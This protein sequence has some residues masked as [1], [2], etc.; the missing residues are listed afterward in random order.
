[1]NIVIAIDSFKGSISSIEAGNTVREAILARYPQE[2]VQVFPLADGGEG[3]V[4]A[5]TQG[6]G[7]SIVPVKVTGPL[8]K[9]V[10][11]RY[12]YIPVLEAA[13]IEMADASGLTLVPVEKRNPLYTTTYGLGE[14]ILTAIDNGCRHFI[15]GIG[16]SATNDAGLGML[17]ALGYKFYQEDGSPCDVYGKNLQDVVRIDTTSCHPLLKECQFE[18]A[19]DVTNP[20]C[21]PQGCSAIYG[22]QKGATP[23]IIQRMDKDIAAFADLAEKATGIKG[24]K[25]PGAGA[26]GGLGF[27]FYTF[28]Q[29]TLTPGIELVL[30]SIKIKQALETADILI[31]GEGRM[32]GQTAMGKA[33]VGIA[34]LAKKANPQCRTIGLCGCATHDAEPVNKHGIDAYFPILHAPMSVEEAMEAHITKQNLTQTIQQIM[35]LLHW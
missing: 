32:D 16:G 35:N 3:T 20:L 6:L 18:I 19:C 12:G 21:G 15:I 24:D 17:T 33:P 14:L 8:G 34:Q 1:M 11:S 23:E 9:P 28:L 7:G 29:G 26:A 25:L 30:K 22:P 2:Q 27:A 5:L 10:K 4:D 31:T 13:V